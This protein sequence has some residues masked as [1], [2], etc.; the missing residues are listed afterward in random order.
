MKSQNNACV[1]LEVYKSPH[2]YPSVVKSGYSIN[3]WLRMT[4]TEM[5]SSLK[6]SGRFFHVFALVSQHPGSR[7]PLTYCRRE[8]QSLRARLARKKN[9]INSGTQ[10]SV[11]DKIGK[12]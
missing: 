5:H 1:S 9:I 4:R 7:G 6:T 12:N 8:Y 11:S 10:G 3:V 2:K